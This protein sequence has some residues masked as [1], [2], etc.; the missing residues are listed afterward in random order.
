MTKTTKPS[1]PAYIRDIYPW[2]YLNTS[3]YDF[4]NRKW[5]QNIL[6]LGYHNI[7]ISELNKEISAKSKILQIGVTLGDQITQTSFS[8]NNKGRYTLLD[9]LPNIIEKCENKHEQLRI[10]YV[11]ANA[12]K[13]FKGDY[14]TIICYMLLH[15]LPPITRQKIINNILRALPIGGKAIFID[16]HQPSSYNPL[17]YIIRAFNRLYQP[18]AEALWKTAI[19]EMAPLKENYSWSKQTYFG[20]IYQK[21][22]ATRES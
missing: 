20:S 13:P 10:N 4:L 1:I 8:L 14:D 11:Y 9:I 22:V 19:K 12:A 3:L 2:L 6:T 5:V 7:L 16:Y 18:F 21:V 15:E 17:K